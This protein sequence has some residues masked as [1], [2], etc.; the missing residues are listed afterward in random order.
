[1]ISWVFDVLICL[2]ERQGYQIELAPYLGGRNRVLALALALASCG[3]SDNSTGSSAAGETGAKE[4]PPKN[5]A[6]EEPP[7]KGSAVSTGTPGGVG[8]VVVNQVGFTLYTTSKDK[9]NSGETSCYGK[10]AKAWV[11]YTTLEPPTIMQ[12]AKPSEL[13]TIKRKDGLTQVTYA[14][15]PVYMYKADEGAARVTG[16]G[17]TSFG[18]TWYTINPKGEIVE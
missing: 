11:P 17:V 7:E 14:G 1:M 2:W 16:Q 6:E 4:Q 8:R 5:V 18:G 3:G 15:Y 13:G 12:K 9:Q 10:C